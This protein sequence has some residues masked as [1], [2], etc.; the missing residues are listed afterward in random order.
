MWTAIRRKAFADLKSRWGQQV[1][2]FFIL[3]LAT[4]TL[5]VALVVQ[6]SATNPWEENFEKTNGA[7][8]W[9]VANSM[10]VDMT[11]VRDMEG[12][13]ATTPI[14]PATASHPIVVDGEKK[15][16]FI[17]SLDGLPNV[18][19]PLVVK[20]R[21]VED[22]ASDEIVL[23]YG[24]AQY[25]DF[26]VGDSV[27]ILT[28]VGLAEFKIVG[29]AVTSHWI[30]YNETTAEIAPSIIYVNP[31]TFAQ[32]TPDETNWVQAFGF[33]IE[34]P[35]ESKA[36][37]ERAHVILN[38]QLES[39][40]EWQWIKQ[41]SNLQT[42]IVVL[43]LSFFSVLGLVTVGFIIAN[44]I[45]GQIIAQFREIGLLKSIGFTPRQVMALLVIEQLTVG[46][47]A[48]II[49]LG[50]GLLISPAFTSPIAEVLYTDAPT[51]NDPLLMLGVVVGI[52]IAVLIFTII[53]A[54][55]GSRADT[56]QAIN[57]GYQRNLK[58]A[59]RPAQLAKKLGLPPVVI[60][61]VKDV[62]A[63]PLRT[64][65][66]VMGLVLSFTVAL[67]AVG[68]DATLK[69]LAENSMYNQGTPADLFVNRGFIPAETT[70]QQ[71]ANMPAVETYYT[72]FTAF[73]WTENNLEFP[74]RLRVLSD[75]YPAFDFGVDSGR[76]FSAENE[77]V[78]GYGLLST[79]DAEVGDE[80]TLIIEGKPLHVKVVGG[81]AEGYNTSH[82]LLVGL[83]TYHAQINPDAEPLDFGLALTNG[84]DRSAVKVD[85]LAQSN[86]QYDILLTNHDAN[87]SAAVLRDI[88]AGLALLLLI[89]AG[90]N[91]M[92]TSWL[93]VRE[94]FRDIAIQ[95][96]LG[97]TPRQ[98]ITSVMTSV[99]VVTIIA[100][101]IGIPVGTFIYEG[102]VANASAQIGGGPNFGVMN[103]VGL[104]LLLPIF[105]ILAALSS[106]WPARHAARLEVVNALRYE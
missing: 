38:S 71:L 30:P 72:E 91:L 98:I 65:L 69:H 105:V 68:A 102:F 21:W 33:R 34:N 36:Y 55:R 50:L 2:I 39:S 84:T 75:D 92:I 64:T 104:F 26:Q 103:W 22:T 67:T 1:L 25:Y 95:K 85:L 19:Q 32:I 94:S 73:G 79:L 74:I 80:I 47:M 3:I 24:F 12:V 35:A 10:A 46:L 61:G 53:P 81:Y 45:G 59:S 101:I 76:M 6:A 88:M 4:A 8:V 62:F 48:A 83:D 57:V 70:R 77:A 18:A 11:P 7:H 42:Q 87:V 16:M 106:F 43:F 52:E 93:S 23:D 51:V 96:S 99:I 27:E 9:L 90:V 44:T 97:L 54:W 40:L 58:G 29:L 31:T 5:T 37:V 63:R 28:E 17:Y 60:L 100:F 13:T 56:V 89:I 20:G 86:Q 66:T 15:E 78:A 49:G 41:M 14:I 82:T